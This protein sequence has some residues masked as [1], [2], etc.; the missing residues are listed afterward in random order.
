MHGASHEVPRMTASIADLLAAP[1]AL[2][3]PGVYD[4]L[5]ARLAVEGR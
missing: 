5:S 3:L 4:S 1:E 2:M